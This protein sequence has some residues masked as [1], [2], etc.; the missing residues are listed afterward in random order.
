MAYHYKLISTLLITIV[1][2][3]TNNEAINLINRNSYKTSGTL[4]A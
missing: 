3:G 2:P 1:E 4:M